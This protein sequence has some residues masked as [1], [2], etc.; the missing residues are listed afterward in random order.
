MYLDEMLTR[1]LIKLDDIETEGRDN[2]R[3]ARKNAIRTIQE[4]ISLL[5]SKAPLP[6]KQV[7]EEEQQRKREDD[8]S[9]NVEQPGQ[10]VPMDVDQ[11]AEEDR[12][13]KE[14]IPLPPCPSSPA[15]QP[16]ECKQATEQNLE[17]SD[18][19]RMVNVQ[20]EPSET[21]CKPLE[22]GKPEVTGEEQYPEQIDQS[23]EKEQGNTVEENQQATTENKAENVP[24]EGEKPEG[25]IAEEKKTE[26]V[27]T[28]QKT[29]NTSKKKKK[30]GAASEEKKN[31][32]ENICKEAQS[33]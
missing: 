25:V 6:S 15:K 32:G 1:E 2:V 7:T 13:H 8:V 11:R 27:S 26:N 10:T 19:N 28:E 29:E 4:T 9:S 30:K 24:T 17:K 5:E 23:V 12:S 18:S 22:A 20:Q 33:G 16:E 21:A 31:A 14:A 3:Q